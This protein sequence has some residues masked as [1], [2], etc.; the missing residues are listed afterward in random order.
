MTNRKNHRDTRIVHA[1]RHPERFSGA[2][3]TPVFHA[4]TILSGSVAELEDK[5]ARRARDEVVTAYGLPG[6]PTMHALEEAL[7]ELEGGYRC[8]LY[9][10]GLAACTGPLMAYLKA[11][12]HLLI[13]D[14]VYG[15]T[16][17]FCEGFLKRFGVDVQYYDPLIA[18]G[19]EALMKPNTTV[20]FTESPGSHTFEVQ[21][22][23]A[24]AA[25]AHRHG[26][27]VLM[28]NT[29]ASPIY[30]DALKHGVDV[31]IQATTKYLNGHSDVIM[32]SV[33]AT[34]AAWPKLRDMHR[35][36]G[37]S[38][39]PDD[40][41]SVLRGLRTIHIRLARHFET[42]LKLAQWIQSQPEVARVLHPALPSD[43]GY[44]LWKRDFTGASGLFGVS[45]KANV[46]REAMNRLIDSL[47]LFGLGASWGGFESLVM[48]TEV[49]AI[50]TA[51]KWHPP[52][53]VF[54]VHAG[55]EAVEDLIE[56]MNQAF[57]AM[58]ATL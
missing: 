3:N 20:V 52:G 56:D 27:T 10:S 46:S 41:Y 23:P 54:R 31:S 40:I 51:T 32:G 26:A 58:R 55:L 24:I 1:G 44:A 15:P 12:D 4:S 34:Q 29:W 19:I 49:V 45:L 35:Q 21:D 30:F 43:P 13:T 33:V 17:A 18:G 8:T 36:V 57:A 37:F 22:I 6:T 28:D 53:P 47:K 42:G 38:A 39:G 5:R 25:A 2:V 14:N 50:R 16:R 48:P 11:G 9:P 7:A